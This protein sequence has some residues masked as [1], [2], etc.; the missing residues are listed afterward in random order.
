MNDPYEIF[1]L[2]PDAG[3]TEIRQRYL[4]LVRQFPPDQAPERFAAV[5]AAYAALRDPARRLH[6]AALHVRDQERLV[7]VDRG[8]SARPAA[9]R[10]A[11]RANL[12]VLADSP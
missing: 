2:T 5:H 4:E 6:D 9:R 10:P 8:R 11:P 3:E 7:R 1:E 12:A